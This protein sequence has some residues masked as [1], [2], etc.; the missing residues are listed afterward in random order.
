MNNVTDRSL[1]LDIADDWSN[2]Y[3]TIEVYAEH[4]GLYPEQADK[5]IKLSLSVRDSKHPRGAL[6]QQAV[7]RVSCGCCGRVVNAGRTV[8]QCGHCDATIKAA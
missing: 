7:K 2:N 4:N 6:A 5:L 8:S 3:L 1:L